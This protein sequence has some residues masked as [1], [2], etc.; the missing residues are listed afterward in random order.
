MK[1]YALFTLHETGWGARAGIGDPTQ[2]TA[3]TDGGVS[4]G[5]VQEKAYF[6]V[7]DLSL[8][9]SSMMLSPRC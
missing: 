5:M 8:Y 6:G 4:V 2:A 3:A 1:L 7:P 9:S